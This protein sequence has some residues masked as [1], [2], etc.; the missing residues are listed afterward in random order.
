MIVE[1]IDC[2]HLSAKDTPPEFRK[3]QM[4]RC[5]RAPRHEF[6]SPEYPRECA[7]FSQATGAE[8]QARRAW[9][10]RGRSDAQ[11]EGSTAIQQ[12]PCSKE[13]PQ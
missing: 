11:S 8:S 12:H 5:Q 3:I 13:S 2:V 1:C 7:K 10:N 6:F 9:L 4:L